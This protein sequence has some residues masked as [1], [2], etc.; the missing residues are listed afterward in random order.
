[1]EDHKMKSKWRVSHTC[2]GGVK[3]TEVYR[4]KDT[5]QPDHSGNREVRPES[6]ESDEEAR[7]FAKHL[8]ESEM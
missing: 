3:I 8:N 6:F 4:L 5:T 7:D 2:A 1:M